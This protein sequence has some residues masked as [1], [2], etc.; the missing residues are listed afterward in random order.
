[1]APPYALQARATIMVP[2]EDAIGGARPRLAAEG[3]LRRFLNQQSSV[4]RQNAGGASL[5]EPSA[6]FPRTALRHTGG[7]GL[8]SSPVIR[9][10]IHTSP[11]MLKSLSAHVFVGG[12]AR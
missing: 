11:F 12:E 5:F 8:N 4:R 3:E 10:W 9:Y 7:G 1:M 2:T 6:N